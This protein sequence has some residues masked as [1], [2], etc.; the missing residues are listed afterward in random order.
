MFISFNNK[1]TNF[2]NKKTNLIIRKLIIFYDKKY[3]CDN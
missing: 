2:N 1:K 3:N